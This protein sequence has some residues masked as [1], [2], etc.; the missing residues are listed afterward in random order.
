[1]ANHVTNELTCEHKTTLD[2]LAGGDPVEPIDFN[3]ILPMPEG[4]H[5][6]VS[7][8]VKDWARIAF[9]VFDLTT[10]LNASVDVMAAIRNSS[11]TSAAGAMKRDTLLRLISDGPRPKDFGDAQF[12]QFI[13]CIRYLRQFGHAGALEWAVA[14]WGTKWNAYRQTRVSDTV[15]RFHTAWTPPTAAIQALSRKRPAES[16]RLRWASEN[17]G[18]ETGIVT[19]KAGEVVYS[20]D[21][22]ADSP[23]AHRL[24]NA[25]LFEGTPPI[26]FEPAAVE[27]LH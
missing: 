1:M 6:D 16:F 11:W 19:F 24:A 26:E 13:N 17:V 27:Q 12:E 5:G 8:T 20:Y 21:A 7:G 23:E 22:V 18:Q 25:V 9:G 4:L 10:L 2:S 14:N 15:V 3:K